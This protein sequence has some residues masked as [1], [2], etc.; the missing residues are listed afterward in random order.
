MDNNLEEEIIKKTEA[1]DKKKK[2]KMK[3]SGKKVFKL[4]NIIDKKR[5]EK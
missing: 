2:K 4:Q 3:V 1:R 5:E